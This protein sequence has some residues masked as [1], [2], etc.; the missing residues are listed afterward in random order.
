MVLVTILG[1]W[2]LSMLVPWFLNPLVANLYWILKA[3]L[4]AVG[5]VVVLTWVVMPILVKILKPWLQ[6]RT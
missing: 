6:H 2:P 4:I 3:L 5:I 1:V